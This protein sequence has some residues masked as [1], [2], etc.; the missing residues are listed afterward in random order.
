LEPLP[1]DFNTAMAHLIEDKGG[2]GEY[3]VRATLAK[4]SH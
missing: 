3:T 1:P 4:S 2:E